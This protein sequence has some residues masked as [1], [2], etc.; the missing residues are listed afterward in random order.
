MG[1]E[2]GRLSLGT[3]GHFQRLPNFASGSEKSKFILLLLIP[4]Q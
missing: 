2:P 3:S 1:Y 4:G